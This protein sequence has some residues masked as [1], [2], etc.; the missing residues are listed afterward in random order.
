MNQADV[1]GSH[2]D[3]ESPAS[4]Q[5]LEIEGTV[6][7]L[8]DE[9]NNAG[10][11]KPQRTPPSACWVLFQYICLSLLAVLMTYYCPDTE[12]R[13]AIAIELVV[14]YVSIIVSLLTVFRSDPGFLEADVVE[15]VCQ[16]DG[17][18]LLGY[19]EEQEDVDESPEETESPLASSSEVTR[20]SNA[21]LAPFSQALEAPVP[22][23]RGTRR[24]ICPTCNVA[25]P[26]RAHHCKFCNK[27]VA[28]FDHHCHFICTCIGERNHCRF[29]VF[30][31]LQTLGFWF[32]CSRVSSSHLG[33]WSAVFGSNATW[34]TA[35][36]VAS[37]IYLYPLTFFSSVIWITHTIFAGSNRTT[38]ECGKGPEHID[39]LR[40]T[41]Y[42]DSPFS[43]G[44][45][46]NIYQFCCVR[47][48]RCCQRGQRV[49][50][51]ILWQTPG[52]IVRDSDDLWEHP[53]ENKYYTCC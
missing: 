41:R 51:P 16:E 8:E 38:F 31:T 18:T 49:W 12:R 50:K 35:L 37:K 9:L 3:A 47:D 45:L 1:N 34:G 36:V 43:K 5:P 11:D 19:E 39:Y 33:F 26:L 23:F 42:T 29:L 28:T 24:K 27:C 13:E 25:P 46:R 14:V 22:L 2:Q 15:Q 44:V 53:F 17:L 52:K 6:E 48:D 20:R 10:E 40:G 21:T 30:V 7:Q 32:C 4:L